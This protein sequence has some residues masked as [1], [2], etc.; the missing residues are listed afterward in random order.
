MHFLRRP[1]SPVAAIAVL[2]GISVIA[3]ANEEEWN[4][5]YLQHASTTELAERN[6]KPA[7]VFDSFVGAISN[8][9]GTL[10]GGGINL[11]NVAMDLNAA[12]PSAPA[13]ASNIALV[14]LNGA[15]AVSTGVMR[16][17]DSIMGQATAV[18]GDIVGAA[19]GIAGSILA[20][21]SGAS[22]VGV[23]FDP[24]ASSSSAVTHPAAEETG[25]LQSG[26]QPDSMTNSTSDSQNG[27]S[28]L[29]SVSL[30]P[31]MTASQQQGDFQDSTQPTA[32]ATGSA[33]PAQNNGPYSAANNAMSSSPQITGAAQSNMSSALCNMTSSTKTSTMPPLPPSYPAQ[34][35]TTPVRA[36][37]TT[38]PLSSMASNST[39]PHPAYAT[40]AQMTSGTS[41]C[42]SMA[43]LTTSCPA[44]VTETC[45]VTETWHSTHYT[46]A[47]TLYSF[48]SIVTV[49][50]TETISSCASPTSY[51]NIE[52][53][54]SLVV[55]ADGT[56]AR[57]Q[58]ECL[59]SD[60]SN[61]SSPGS[62]SYSSSAPTTTAESNS[63]I[64]Y[65]VALIPDMS[66][67][68]APVTSQ[69]AIL[70]SFTVNLPFVPVLPVATL[71][72]VSSG[73]KTVMCKD[74]TMVA[75]TQ[76]CLDGLAGS[77]TTSLLAFRASMAPKVL[78]RDVS[79]DAMATS[80][81][82]PG[83]GFTEPNV[84]QSSTSAMRPLV[85]ASHL[86]STSSTSLGAHLPVKP[87]ANPQR[88]ARGAKAWRLASKGGGNVK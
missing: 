2:I 56:L 62:Y 45:T 26:S 37:S 23:L 14:N 51:A 5:C 38:R 36:Y 85:P 57:S 30:S 16:D 52:Q 70:E 20:S 43:S 71:A 19:T 80:D 40:S 64:D 65:V 59:S 8:V 63:P 4:N 60:F 58:D 24:Q 25:G 27:T 61:S 46:E 3:M 84:Q 29:S 33:P 31:A 79:P 87:S 49:T 12:A 69:P 73:P 42:P 68:P 21:A 47:A 9:A 88:F 81:H 13:G 82:A 44:Q 78:A 74:G 15:S 11:A 32:S 53:P 17:V 10:L 72:P 77:S 1:S 6:P 66:A 18:V 35:F 7:S 28:I 76:D 22:N 67:V 83:A 41:S 75:S 39:A 55:C 48:M 34:N 86:T 54:E 50:C